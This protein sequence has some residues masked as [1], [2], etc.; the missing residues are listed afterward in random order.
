MIKK[1]FHLN[2]QSSY[3]AP[4]PDNLHSWPAK[5]VD[6]LCDTLPRNGSDNA[7]GL[8]YRLQ[9]NQSELETRTKDLNRE[10]K[11]VQ[12]ELIAANEKLKQACDE[13]E[14]L[15]LSEERY[16]FLYEES[17]AVNAV[18]GMD[19][20][21]LD[22]NKQAL[23]SLGYAKE[24][25]L[26]QPLTN[27]VVPRQREDVRRQLGAS[28]RGEQPPT[29]EVS[30]YAQNGDLRHFILVPGNLVYHRGSTP[31][32]FIYI[33]LD[34]TK[35]KE[36]EEQLQNRTNELL[37]ANRELKAFAHSVSH[38]LRNP[39]NNMAAMV[40]V[41][42]MYY[43]DL[44]DADGNKCIEQIETNIYRMTSTIS[45][46]LELSIISQHELKKQDVDL[47][48]ITD[49]FLSELKKSNPWRNVEVIVQS[50]IIV[51]ADKGL[52]RLALENLIRNAW[53]YTSK[54]KN[55]R[56][57]I[58]MQDHNGRRV[59]YIKDNGAGFDMNH[60]E[61]IFEPFTRLHS[62]EKYRGTGIGLSIVQR[63]VHKHGGTICA[64]GQVDRGAT[65]YF[66]LVT[67]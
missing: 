33:A 37:A 22:I 40:D 14:R 11:M 63:V 45:N 32:S 67:G 20:T 23:N 6:T 3:D 7:Q 57:E 24:E 56:I 29:T 66:T 62:Q 28:A 58:G 34:M 47:S 25:M 46:L 16:R 4:V 64:E 54:V 26:G 49:S 48:A 13:Y 5:Q 1:L 38:D 55:P 15:R 43:A 61:I 65:F 31:H 50:G 51:N 35:H 52:I 8:I 2:K 39:L 27:F 19:G 21:I 36:M 30:I 10:F 44:M 17:P 60:A 9:L 41:L 59:V 18:I 12:H 53:K 42:K